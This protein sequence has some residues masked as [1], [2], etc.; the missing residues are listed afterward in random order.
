M[1]EIEVITV[2][3]L[4]DAVQQ[5]LELA[6]ITD[7]EF[8]QLG[9]IEPPEASFRRPTLVGYLNLIHSNKVQI[10]GTEE[11]AYLDSLAPKV[12]LG[13]LQKIIESRPAVL[14]FTRKQPVPEDL[15]ALC[16]DATLPVWSSGRSGHE[17]LT[18]LQ[19]TL[20]RA[21]AKRITLHGVFLEVYSIGVLITGEAGVGKSELALELMTRGH[22][23]I[24]DDAPEFTLIAPDVVDGTCP[25]ILQDCLEV[26]GLGVLNV[27]EMFGDT[28]VKRNK[29]LRL[30]IHLRP[31]KHDHVPDG[32]TRLFG[33]TGKREVL[34]V[35]VPKLTIP[36]APGRNLAVLVE[37]AVRNHILKSKGID[38]AQIF[39][40]RQAHQMRKEQL[41]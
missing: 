19:Y 11:L 24:A 28:A 10:I 4:F 31:E 36:V 5:R 8:G 7:P 27:R 15:L 23:L 20:A 38:A 30:I 13:T 2:G 17:L 18:F 14:V 37:A 6:W 34:D 25:E 41:W 16:V 26:R 3:A 32:T 22:R 29:Y 1:S 40:D 35:K 39:I 33:D 21:L 9:K 12:R